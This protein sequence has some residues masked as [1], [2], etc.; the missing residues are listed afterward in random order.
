MKGYYMFTEKII[1]V[2]LETVIAYLNEPC[3]K[4]TDL[5]DIRIH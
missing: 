2:E 4:T 1:V 3:T 5:L